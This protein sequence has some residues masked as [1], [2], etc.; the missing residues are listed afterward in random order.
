MQWY[1]HR[2]V[3]ATCVYAATGS[4]VPTLIACQGSIIPDSIEGNN[5]NSAEWK[6]NHRKLSHFWPV[7]L[8]PVIACYFYLGTFVLPWTAPQ[9]AIWAR[10]DMFGCILGGLSYFILWLCIGALCH[11]AED[12]IC[13]GVPLLHP[14]GKRVGVRLF[15][16]K[17]HGEYRTSLIL[18]IIFLGIALCRFS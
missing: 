8:V 12:F 6:D 4:I 5:Y 16:V 14:R 1:N 15:Y 3:T 7:Y 2:I 11:L 18:N 13:G 17:S 9:W 10:N